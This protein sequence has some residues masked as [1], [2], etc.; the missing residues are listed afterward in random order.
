MTSMGGSKY[1]VTFID[2]YSRYIVVVPIKAKDEVLEVLKK[3]HPWFER[4]YK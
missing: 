1:Y 2:E 4:K 3:F